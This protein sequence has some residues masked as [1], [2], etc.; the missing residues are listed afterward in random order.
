M[1]KKNIGPSGR[2]FRLAIAMILLMI[3][4][5]QKSWIVFLISLF[6]F[7]EA[8]MQWCLIYQLLGKNSCPIDSDKQDVK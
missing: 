6:V 7:F 3:A 2:I 1:L 8:W 4:V 5:W